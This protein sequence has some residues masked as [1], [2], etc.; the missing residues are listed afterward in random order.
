[1]KIQVELNLEDV[2]EDAV[3]NEATL[4][5]EFTSSVRLAV[6]RELKEK[7]KDEL[8]REICNPIS[9]KIEEIVRES[10]SDLIENASEKKYR[11][12]IDYMDDELTVDEFIRGRMKKVIDRGIESM[13]ESRAKSFVDELRKRYD[14]A[15]ATFIVNNMRKQNMLKDEKIAELLKDNPD[16]R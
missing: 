11:F 9:E 8:M 16:E 5:E 13:I 14:M 6:V 4:K 2:F 1:M 7:F 12:R 3:Y 15:F 10:M